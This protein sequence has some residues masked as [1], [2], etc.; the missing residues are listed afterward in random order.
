MVNPSGEWRHQKADACAA[1]MLYG[2]LED[3]LRVPLAQ[4]Y[5]TAIKR[6]QASESVKRVNERLA[7]NPAYE[8]QA[9]KLDVNIGTKDSWKNDLGVSVAD[10]PYAHIGAAM[11]SAIQSEIA[12]LKGKNAGV[13][14]LMRWRLA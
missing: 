9:A 14:A 13:S 3:D 10:I 2:S 11:Q 12:L 4:E 6:Y 5:R 1:K 7:D 8:S